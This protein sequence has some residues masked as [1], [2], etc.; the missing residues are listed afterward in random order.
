M[1]IHT[2]SYDCIK[3]QKINLIYLQ[4]ALEKAHNK[5]D[6]LNNTLDSYTNNN[7][8]KYDVNKDKDLYIQR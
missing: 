6:E 2:I 7:E 3:C 1:C 8:T 4:C 5:I